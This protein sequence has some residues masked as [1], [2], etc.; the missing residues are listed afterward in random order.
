MKPLQSRAATP[1]AAAAAQD[2]HTPV[3][4]WR[5]DLPLRPPSSLLPSL[6]S[7][8]HLLN[9]H[10]HVGHLPKSLSTKTP[11]DLSLE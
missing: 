9:P 2:I 6:L 3:W 8:P 11:S 7:L 10:S 4:E 1:A 5:T